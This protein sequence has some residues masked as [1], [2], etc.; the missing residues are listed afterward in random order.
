M[1]ITKTCNVTIVNGDLEIRMGN[2]LTVFYYKGL[3]KF[4]FRTEELKTFAAMIDKGQS[5]LAAF[6]ESIKKDT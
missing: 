2:N 1:K 5:E 4:T 6:Y 3:E